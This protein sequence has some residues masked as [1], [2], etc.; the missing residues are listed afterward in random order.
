[1]IVQGYGATEVL[2]ALYECGAPLCMESFCA[3]LS[4]RA[5]EDFWRKYMAQA[6]WLSMR[7]KYKEPP[8]GSYI[9]MSDRK[10]PHAAK[11]A[12]E[13]KEELLARLREE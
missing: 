13:L 9:S 2:A 10:K 11:T 8:M 5:Q 4:R 12:E 7:T 1:M 3:Y 6:L